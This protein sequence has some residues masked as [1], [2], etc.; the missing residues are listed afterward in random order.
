VPFFKKKCGPC[1]PV[2]MLKTNTGN[3]NCH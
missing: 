1:S 3:Y 2:N